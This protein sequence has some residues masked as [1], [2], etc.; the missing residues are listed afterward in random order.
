MQLTDMPTLPAIMTYGR[1]Q[2]PSILP[3]VFGFVN[4]NGFIGPGVFEKAN[5]NFIEAVCI[6]ILGINL[7]ASIVVQKVR[8]YEAYT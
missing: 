4:L 5:E 3:P 2:D 1:H 6:N 8:I 7:G